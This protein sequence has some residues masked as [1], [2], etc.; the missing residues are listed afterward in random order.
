MESRY[1]S[2]NQHLKKVFG[3]RVK[4]IPLD[5]GLNCPNRDGTIG[6]GGCIYCDAKGSGTGLA[7]KLSLEDQVKFFLEKFRAKG[8]KKFIL[9]F[10][11]FTNTY[12]DPPKLKNLYDLVKLSREIVGLAIGTRPDCL[13]EGKVKLIQ[14]YQK[15][16]YYVW[17]ELGLQSKHNETLRFINRGHTYE[18]FLAGYELLKKYNL[19]AVVHIIFGLPKENRE[20]MLLTVKELAKLRVD[21]LKFHALYVVKHTPLEKLYKEGHYEPL[22]LEKYTDL[23]AE[24]L[25]LLPP[26]TVIHRLTS[27]PPRGDLVAPEWLLN[28][29]K[30]IQLIH[31]ILTD[32]NW[33]QGLFFKG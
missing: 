16:G 33:S 17:V 13:D 23:V 1:Y 29:N 5:A 26:E 2:L 22:T 6:H 11:S 3:E 14:G 24:S 10:Q 15:E 18:Q 7:K 28:K 21:G 31:S 19:P 30:I 25:T 4:K 9:Y 8:Y 27:D 32:R 12:A 20:M